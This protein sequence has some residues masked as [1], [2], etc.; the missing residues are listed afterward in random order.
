M[1]ESDLDKNLAATPYKLEKAKGRGQVAKS[2]D[3]AGAVVF[4]VAMAFLMAQGWTVW[5]QQF[6]L[7]RAILGQLGLMAGSPGAIWPLIA[8]LFRSSLLLGAPFFAILMVAAIV[9]NVLQTGPVLSAHPIKPDWDRLNPATGF[10]RVF[11]MRTL[12]VAGRACLKLISLAVVVYFALRDL[13]PQFYQLSGLSPLGLM[14]TLIADVGSLGIE[15]AAMLAFIALI[16]LLYTRHEF[17]KKMRMSRHEMKDEMKHRD[18]DPR[19]RA[20]LRQLRKEMLK[21]SRA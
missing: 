20:R 17:A 16:D 4:T 1:A 12:F 9:G 6:G 19:I 7:D 15:C 18:G 8:Q 13:L 2:P 11:S 21:R 14:H 10:K 5:R 3:V